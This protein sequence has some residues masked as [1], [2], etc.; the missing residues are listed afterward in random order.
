MRRALAAL[1][2]ALAAGISLYAIYTTVVLTLWYWSEG[3]FWIIV[4]LAPLVLGP[5]IFAL[6]LGGYLLWSERD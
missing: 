4:L 3:S 5:F 1:L 6:S 2:F